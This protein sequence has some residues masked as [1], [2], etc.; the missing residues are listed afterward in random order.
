MSSLGQYILDKKLT[1]YDLA[2]Q[3]WLVEKPTDLISRDDIHV[4]FGNIEYSGELSLQNFDGEEIKR[5]PEGI[6]PYLTHFK[7]LA[8]VNIV[9]FRASGN[10][11]I[12]YFFQESGTIKEAKRLSDDILKLAE[13]Y[14][15]KPFNPFRITLNHPENM[16][17]VHIPLNSKNIEFLTKLEEK[18]EIRVKT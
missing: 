14:K 6:E 2:L 5:K 17:M 7:N 13:S 8:S 1:N 3:V 16:M 11:I 18:L 15:L 4:I 10:A 9:Y 12:Q